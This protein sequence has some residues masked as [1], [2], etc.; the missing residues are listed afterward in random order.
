M[1]PSELATLY[2]HAPTDAE[3]AIL[4]PRIAQIQ[5]SWGKQM[6]GDANRV[7]IHA[8][9]WFSRANLPWRDLPAEFGKWRSVHVRF[10]RWACT[11]RLK[12][13][14]DE[15]EKNPDL[16]L[17]CVDSTTCRAAP[18]AAGAQ[19]KS[20]LRRLLRRVKS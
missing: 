4:G 8:L 19:K 16:S 17:L 7:F 6:G 12:K 2:R 15:L 1:L 9:L 3:W 13:L 20:S 11:G 14:F 10:F 5:G 18:C